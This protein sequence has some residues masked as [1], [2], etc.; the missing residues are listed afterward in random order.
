MKNILSQ[1][2]LYNETID[3]I[4]PYS[5]FKLTVL[6]LFIRS[7]S[8]FFTARSEVFDWIARFLNLRIVHYRDITH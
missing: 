1:R 7:I 4:E 8:N 6:I 2:K 5:E 3:I